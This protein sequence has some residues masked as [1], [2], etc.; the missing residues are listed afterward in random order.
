MVDKN[1]SDGFEEQN[2]YFKKIIRTRISKRLPV[3]F[4]FYTGTQEL[5]LTIRTS[6]PSSPPVL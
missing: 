4:V 3:Y 2:Q 6:L 1:I 5:I